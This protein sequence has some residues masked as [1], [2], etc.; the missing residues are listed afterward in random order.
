[1][2]YNG[3]FHSLGQK[4]DLGNNYCKRGCDTY[5]DGYWYPKSVDELRL[6]CIGNAKNKYFIV[7]RCDYEACI[8]LHVLGK[9]EMLQC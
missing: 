2:Y 3:S 6:S 5:E 1:M 9:I 4:P 7:T 8:T